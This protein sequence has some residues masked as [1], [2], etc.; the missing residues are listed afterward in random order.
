MRVRVRF[1]A[2]TRDAVGAP[3]LDVEVPDAWRLADL[4]AALARDHPRLARYEG[5]ALLALDGAFA[6]PD[7][8][9]REGAEVAVMPPVSGGAGHLHEGPLSLDEVVASLRGEGAGAV[10][11]FL[12][13]VRP[14]SGEAAGARVVR[15]R[16]EAHE[17]MAEREM[18]ALRAQAVAKFGLVDLAV[19]HRLGVLE[20]GEPIVAVAASARHRRAAFE[21]AQWAMDELKARVPVWKQEI[22][23]DG[24][25]RWINDPTGGWEPA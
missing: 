14:T 10:V 20:V 15:L 19:R 4:W 2:G 5:H 6:A 24:G 16:F 7:A 1:F 22:D 13:V 11:A 3:H 8:P 25:T 18:A 9:L 23:A 12:G 17:A 21:A